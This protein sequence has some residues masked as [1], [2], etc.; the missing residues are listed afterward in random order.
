MLLKWELSATTEGGHISETGEKK[1][2]AGEL[3]IETTVPKCTIQ[4]A[5]GQII[6]GTVDHLPGIVGAAN[7]QK[8]G[9]KQKAP[10]PSSLCPTPGTAKTTDTKHHIGQHA[11]YGHHTRYLKHN[12]A[13]M[14]IQREFTCGIDMSVQKDP[15]L[16]FPRTGPDSRHI[17]ARFL[18]KKRIDD[19]LVEHKLK[20]EQEQGRCAENNAE[21]GAQEE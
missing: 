19:L 17:H 5:A 11:N 18:G 1:F 15:P 9:D 4:K 14:I 21:P 8:K 12:T 16:H 20:E 3:H 2:S 13:K 7:K 6:I 10:K